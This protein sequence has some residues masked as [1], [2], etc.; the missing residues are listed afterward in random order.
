VLPETWKR[1]VCRGLDPKR[2]SDLLAERGLLLCSTKRHRAAA[3]TLPGEGKRRVYV[4]SGAILADDTTN[5]AV[6]WQSLIYAS[7]PVPHPRNP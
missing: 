3:V 4:L 2:T 1:D 7:S 6:G 5:G